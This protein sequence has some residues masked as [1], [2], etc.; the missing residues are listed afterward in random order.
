M[1]Q[2][3]LFEN[4]RVKW[5]RYPGCVKGFCK[6]CGVLVWY[7]TSTNKGEWIEDD[8]VCQNCGTIYP[9]EDCMPPSDLPVRSG[10]DNK[11]IAFDKFSEHCR[12]RG[13]MHEGKWLCGEGAQCWADW[14]PCTED[15][16]PLLE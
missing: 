6:M 16:C 10:I 8:C 4:A 1:N 5:F 15:N 14:Q 2:L 11:V 3:S 12:H 9:Q 7:G 13:A